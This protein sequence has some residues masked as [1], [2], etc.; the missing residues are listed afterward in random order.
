MRLRRM[1]VDP[2]SIHVVATPGT[3]QTEESWRLA[4]GMATVLGPEVPV[5]ER[6]LAALSSAPLQ[7]MDLL[8]RRG[9]R[10]LFSPTIAHGLASAWAADRR[11]RELS[12]AEIWEIHIRYPEVD[13]AAVYDSDID[14]LVLP[15]SYV[16]RDIERI[17]LHEL[18]HALTLGH[19]TVRASLLLDLPRD[20]ACHALD[21]RY[22]D[23]ADPATLE[24]RV[25]EVIAE[26]Y[27]FLAV[28]REAELPADVLSEVVFILTSVAE[29]ETRI[30]FEFDADTGRTATRV[31]RS[32]IVSHEDPELGHFF[33]SPPSMDTHLEARALGT[34]D[35]AAE[36]LR[37]RRAA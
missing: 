4:R 7:H 14:A 36:R 15:T 13:T 1:P 32:E 6:Y 17:V 5:I 9:T 20:I 22:G 23:P 3:R 29:D 16:A 25:N 37:R 33:A 10:I 24:R 2:L 26:S 34:N 30:R 11:G 27:V 18:G 8:R 21:P 31:A 35:L 19:V 28:G 12:P